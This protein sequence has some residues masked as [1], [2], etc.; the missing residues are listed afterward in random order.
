M[1]NQGRGPGKADPIHEVVQVGNQGRDEGKADPNH[2][3]AQLQLQDSTE[4][5]SA[6]YG[7]KGE[8]GVAGL[9]RSCAMQ[10]EA[11]EDDGDG[12]IAA[13]GYSVSKGRS[14]KGGAEADRMELEG[15]GG[16]EEPQC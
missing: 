8:D 5:F 9:G 11:T 1:G 12:G 4:R 10:C 13:H 3:V 2:E 6:R 14:D 16:F 7:D 15:G